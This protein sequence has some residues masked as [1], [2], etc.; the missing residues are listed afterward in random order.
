MKTT[1]ILLSF[2]MPFFMISCGPAV[3]TEIHNVSVSQP[4]PSKPKPDRPEDFRATTTPR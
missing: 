1:L 4:K 3:P 2:S